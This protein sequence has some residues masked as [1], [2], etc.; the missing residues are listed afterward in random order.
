MKYVRLDRTTKLSGETRRTIKSNLIRCDA[1]FF[2]KMLG[3]FK[4]ADGNILLQGGLAAARGAALCV[5]EILP[6]NR[7]LGSGR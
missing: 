3:N 2:F 5:G 7:H 1:P 6:P 4:R